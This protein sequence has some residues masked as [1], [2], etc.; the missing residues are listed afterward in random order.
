[1][2]ERPEIEMDRNSFRQEFRGPF[3]NPRDMWL[4]VSIWLGAALLAGFGGWQ[5]LGPMG[6]VVFTIPPAMWAGA[7]VAGLFPKFFF[8]APR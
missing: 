5:L 4:A 8:G 2:T 3:G 7:G 1:M 6:G